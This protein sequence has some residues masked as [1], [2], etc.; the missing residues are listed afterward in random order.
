MVYVVNFCTEEHGLTVLL[1]LSIELNADCYM[2]CAY[3][4]AYC[5]LSTCSSLLLCCTVATCV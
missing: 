5:L 1:E 4:G 2:N 3:T